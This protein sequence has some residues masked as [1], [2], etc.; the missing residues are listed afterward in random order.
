MKNNLAELSDRELIVQLEKLVAQEK[1]T[2]T[3]IVRHLSEVE[4]RKL[5]LELGYSSLFDYAT[6]GLGYGESSALRRIKV[7]RAGSKVPEIFNYLA[8]EKVSLS[9]L[10]ACSG[11]LIKEGGIQVL[12]EL[13][14]KTREE[15]EW[16][17]ASYNPV[18]SNSVKDKIK[19]V[20]VG[21]STSPQTDLFIEKEQF[22]TNSLRIR[23]GGNSEE[24][25]KIS[26]S[27]GSEFMEKLTRAQELMFSGNAEDLLLENIFGEALELYIEKHCPKEKQKRREARESKSS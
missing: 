23:S 8:E 6:R 2:T 18:S 13:R 1:E 15:A 5:Y 25:F 19:K 17:S 7:A 24:K 3:D 20:V 4:V 12:E 21:V 11:V 10:H 22:P 16:I 14:G 9:A 26:F 27:V